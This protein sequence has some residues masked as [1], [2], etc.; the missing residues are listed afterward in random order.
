MCGFLG[1]VSLNE[2][3]ETGFNNANNL[4]ECRGPDAKRVLKGNDNL[5]NYNLIF[6]RLAIIDLNENANQP[7]VDKSNDNILMFNGEIYNH[8][9]LK[10]DLEKKYS[11]NFSTSHSDSETLLKGLSTYSLDFINKLR[12]QFALFFID[13]KNKKIILARDRLGQKPLYYI[14]DSN[15]LK[16]SSNLNSLKLICDNN[17]LSEEHIIQYLNIGATYSPNTI[18]KNIFK[19]EP[20][21]IVVIDYS[22]GEFKV[23][24]NNYWSINSFIGEKEFR[25]D[26]FM[27]L[28]S[29]SVALRTY[30]D[31]PIASF[32]SGGIDSTSIVKNLHDN[33]INLSTFTVS[34]KEKKYDESYW[35]SQVSKKYRTSHSSVTLSSDFCFENVIK[36]LL[37]IDEPVADPSVIP[38]YLISKEIS[39]EFKVAISG[40]GGDELLGGYKRTNIVLSNK[41]NIINNLSYLYN[42]YPAFLGTGNKFLS[43][44]SNPY[45][46]Y[47]SFLQDNKFLKLLGINSISSDNANIRMEI[48]DNLYKDLLL[49]DYKFFLPEIMNYKVDRM[50]MANSLEVR[51]PFLD[52]KLVEYILSHKTPY[53]D[54]NNSKALLKNYLLND[55]DNSFLNR[56]K[57]GFSFNLENFVYK[58]ISEINSIIKKGTVVNYLDKNIVKKLSIFKSRMNAIRIWKLFVLE[59]Y[60][61]NN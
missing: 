35:A 40:D 26:E 11:I 55:F 47:A 10:K 3:T 16:F 60:L 45:Q 57:Q 36:I 8:L 30:S 9:D 58:N 61:S 33:N 12:G 2:I 22:S 54:S 38:T 46:S 32:L 48:T 31:V 27:D 51:S 43:K 39:K 5:I 59:N 23:S 52:H 53:L 28:F 50:S 17:Q 15:N 13:F 4:I 42:V 1:A 20:S 6:N 34:M 18:F 41:K 44:S 24:Y 37:Q 19:V 14:L 7:M 29:E 56:P 25:N 21:Q 49:S